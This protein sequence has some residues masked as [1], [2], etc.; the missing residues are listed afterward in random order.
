MFKNYREVKL[1]LSITISP[2]SLFFTED[3]LKIYNVFILFGD[4]H[5]CLMWIEINQENHT[6]PHWFFVQCKCSHERR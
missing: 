4:H 1:F 5:F 6:E 3:S 2:V